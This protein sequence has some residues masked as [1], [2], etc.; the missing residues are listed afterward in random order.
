MSTIQIT[1]AGLAL[2]QSA[3][4]PIVLTSFKLG[5]GVNYIPTGGQTALQGSIVYTGVPGAPEIQDGNTAL[6]PILLAADIGPYT[7]GEV[8]YYYNTTLFAVLVFEH[9]ITKSPLDEVAGTGGPI[10]IDAFLPM[11][12]ANYQMWANVAQSNTNRASVVSGP[13]GL[14]YSVNSNPNLY[15]VQAVGSAKPFLAY[16]DRQ[17][18]WNFDAWNE[19]LSTS[20]LHS[21]TTAIT[22]DPTDWATVTYGGSDTVIMQVG[23]GQNA[24]VCRYVTA[25]SADGSGNTVLTLN[26]PMTRALVDGTVV[27]FYVPYSAT[28]GVAPPLPNDATFL[29]LSVTNTVG[30]NAFT[31]FMASPPP[32]GS[33]APS[34]GKFTTL[35]ASGNVNLS[36]NVTLGAVTATSINGAIIGGTTAAAGHFTTVYAGDVQAT[37]AEIATLTV[38][39][40]MDIEAPLQLSNG[41]GTAGQVPTNTGGGHIVWATPSS[42]S[43]FN[44]AAPGPIGGTTPSTGTFTTI[45]AANFV[46]TGTLSL[47]GSVGT[48]GQVA[49]SAGPGQPATWTSIPVVY[50]N[51]NQR[52]TQVQKTLRKSINS[53]RPE[54]AATQRQLAYTNYEGARKTN[55]DGAIQVWEPDASGFYG[56]A[57]TRD[58]AMAMEGYLE[59]FTQT[60]I[61]AVAS[62]WLSKSNLGTGE[63]PDHIGHDGTVYWKPGSSSDVGSRAPVDGNFFLIQMWWLA[64]VSGGSTAAS[65]ATY[66]TNKVALKGLVETGVTYDGT[67]GLV[68]ISDSTPFVGFGFYDSVTLTGKVLFPSIL[69]VRAYQMLAEMEYAL[70]NYSEAN[71]LLGVADTIKAGINST[72]VHRRPATGGELAAGYNAREM[73]YGYLATTKGANQIDLWSTPYL[74]WCDIVSEADARAIGNYLYYAL[75]ST[76]DN[77][78]RGGIRSIDKATDYN[79]GVACYQTYFITT[80]YGTYQNGGFWPTPMPWVIDAIAK[81]DPAKARAKYLEMHSYSLE[82]GANSL[83]EWWNTTGTFGAQKYLTSTAALLC[84]NQPNGPMLQVEEWPGIYRTVANETLTLVLSAQYDGIITQTLTKC[85]SGSCTL[86]FAI[87]GT[88]IGGTAN[89]VTTAANTQSHTSGNTFKKGDTITMTVTSNSSCVDISFIMT[90]LRAA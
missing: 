64:Y 40:L 38:N 7:F 75:T 31:A 79:P 65:A 56:K 32:I 55:T 2:M 74:V 25:V 46:A 58:Q 5:T 72:L 51:L 63:V 90:I 60:E 8:G 48:S 43:S 14:P 69:A 13:E 36:G 50:P 33:V 81:I 89:S 61:Q 23:T 28:G 4:E 21:S 78:F 34:S 53:Y 52:M 11:V 62:Y 42:G 71:R 59:Y 9:T 17:G 41:L 84:A 54:P 88:Q 49:T 19:Q 35:Q 30:G 27:K 66:S 44:P 16:T 22:I 39:T 26:A 87:N 83:N 76:T 47:N 67:T 45:T 3:V 10:V 82:Q 6:Y 86:A 20:T 85:A 1:D 18:L 15:I 37:Q 12:G 73:A 77:Y 24:A 57:W 29:T 68:A 80:A 70:A